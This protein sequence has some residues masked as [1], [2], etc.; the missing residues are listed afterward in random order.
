[1][2]KTLSF[3]NKSRKIIQVVGKCAL[4]S[5]YFSLPGKIARSVSVKIRTFRI[6]GSNRHVQAA[7]R[8]KP[9]VGGIPVHP[10]INGQFSDVEKN[11]ADFMHIFRKFE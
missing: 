2:I 10:K 3:I 4:N 7:R 5:P 1:M 9:K 8:T 6:L 11:K